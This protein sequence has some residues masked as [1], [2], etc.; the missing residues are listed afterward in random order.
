MFISNLITEL[1]YLQI[2]YYSIYML[3]KTPFNRPFYPLFTPLLH[4]WRTSFSARGANRHPFLSLPGLLTTA[5]P[6]ASSPIL[7]RPTYQVTIFT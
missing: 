4:T 5:L 3:S 2:I 1:Y 6:F 7:S